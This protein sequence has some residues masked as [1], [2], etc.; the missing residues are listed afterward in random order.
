[1]MSHEVHHVG[2]WKESDRAVG[3]DAAA[4]D[5]TEAFALVAFPEDHVARMIVTFA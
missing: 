3:P 2:W 1:M 4:Q 5:D